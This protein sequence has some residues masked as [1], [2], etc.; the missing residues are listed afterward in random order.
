MVRMPVRP[1]SA[2]E[3]SVSVTPPSP[4]R[5]QGR[6]RATPAPAEPEVITHTVSAFDPEHPERDGGPAALGDEDPHEN[7]QTGVRAQGGGRRGGTWLVALAAL[8][9]VLGLGSAAVMLG[10]DGGRVSKWLGLRPTSS[11]PVAAKDPGKPVEA[12][13][14]EGTVPPVPVDATDAGTGVVAATPPSVPPE[15]EDGDSEIAPLSLDG[16][17]PG[18]PIVKKPGKRTQLTRKTP[19]APQATAD[20]GTP[21]SPAAEHGM[22]TLRT[23]PRARVFLGDKLLGLTPLIKLKLP[24]GEHVLRLEELG[25]D[26][27]ALL[28]PV[29]IPSGEVLTMDTPLA[30]LSEE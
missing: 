12:K 9:L 24:A 30:M 6:R 18:T 14:P 23:N 2:G 25:R 17:S 16:T 20:A 5:P 7:T 29:D 28:L 21:A 4:R 15:V 11:E 3:S 10:L 22:L 8:L 26:A 27:K 1:D 19:E 13:G